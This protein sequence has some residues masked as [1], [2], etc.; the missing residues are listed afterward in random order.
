M[1][2]RYGSNVTS[3]P[4]PLFD[5][6]STTHRA[7]LFGSSALLMT[8]STILLKWLYAKI[9]GVETGNKRTTPANIKGE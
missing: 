6:L 4:Y 7:I 8:G 9:N 3:Y 5:I 2:R 1:L